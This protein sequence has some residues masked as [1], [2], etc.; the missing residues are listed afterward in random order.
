MQAGL[1]RGL[2]QEHGVGVLVLVLVLVL[3]L[4]GSFGII[5]RGRLRAVCTRIE[6]R[7]GVG[8][9]GFARPGQRIS[10][11]GTRLQSKELMAESI[12]RKFVC[13]S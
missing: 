10:V 5:H 7:V 4:R 6:F 2:R 3:D 13:I 12:L 9:A 8:E 11:S 1:A